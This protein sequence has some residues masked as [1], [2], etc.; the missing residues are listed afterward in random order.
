MVV[1]GLFGDFLFSFLIK[2]KEI[3]LGVHHVGHVVARVSG[4]QSGLVREFGVPCIWHMFI[5]GVNPLSGVALVELVG[6]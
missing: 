2:G 4:S 6:Q 1:F 5:H 3:I